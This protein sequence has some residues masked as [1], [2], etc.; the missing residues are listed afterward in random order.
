MIADQ[1]FEDQRT[2]SSHN[3]NACYVKY[4]LVIDAL[5]LINCLYHYSCHY[6]CFSKLPGLADVCRICR[7]VAYACCEVLHQRDC[8]SLCMLLQTQ[9]QHHVHQTSC[10]PGVL[11]CKCT[12]VVTL[13]ETG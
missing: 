3:H 10:I 4:C 5:T 11:V 8:K 12:M 6:S 7:N 13:V 1:C 2:G 9:T